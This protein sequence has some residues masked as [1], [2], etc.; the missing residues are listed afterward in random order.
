MLHEW[1]QSKSLS[2]GK[3]ETYTKNIIKYALTMLKFMPC[4]TFSKA[5]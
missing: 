4:F 1:P 2:V 5:V 3:A